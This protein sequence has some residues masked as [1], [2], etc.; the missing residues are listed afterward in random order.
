VKEDD[1]AE[2]EKMI[3]ELEKEVDSISSEEIEDDL[4]FLFD[5]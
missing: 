4:S 2:E 1:T 3:E 5:D